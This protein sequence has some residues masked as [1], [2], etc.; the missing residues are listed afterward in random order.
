MFDGRVRL[1]EHDVL[2]PDG[3]ASTYLVDQSLACAVATLLRVGD[4][5]ALTFQYRFPLDRW[6]VDLPGGAC[7]PDEDPAVAAARECEEELGLIPEDLVP[8]V[9]YAANPGRAAWPVHIFSGT[10][11]RAGRAASGDAAEVV[12]GRL[13]T[14]A[15]VDA[16][17]DAGDVVD[18]T[19]L[20]S[21]STARRR[22]LL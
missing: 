10:R 17:V 12:R 11:S 2:L 14:V 6:V 18:P 22:G 8:L 15:E 20:I 9:T 4:R 3:R 1:V 7:G 16:L 21:W 13:L 19:L 5:F